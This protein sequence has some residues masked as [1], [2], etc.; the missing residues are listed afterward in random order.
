MSLKDKIGSVTINAY[1]KINLFLD[2]TD[3]LPNGYHTLNNV[4]QQIDLHDEVTVSFSPDNSIKISVLCSDPDIPCDNRNIAY[5][6]AE[7][8]MSETGITGKA[9]IKIVKNIPVMAGLGGS[10]TDG[11][12]VLSA[13]NRINKNVLPENELENMGAALGADL[14]FCIRGGAALCNGIGEKMQDICGLP[15][16]SILIVKPDFP[17]STASAYALYDKAPLQSAVEP[18][19]LLAALQSGNLIDAG[20]NL[21]N[22]FEQLYN[23]PKI[24]EIKETLL[25]LGAAGAALSGSGSALYGIFKEKEK[26]LDAVSKLNFSHKYITKPVFLLEK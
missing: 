12:A 26:A 23:D 3:T 2:I 9:E 1:A 6:A 22:I 13:L 7:R 24:R 25:K 5:K 18:G 16:C 8:F 11:A 21:Y 15:H 10:S 17:C 14:P 4:M 20:K 19:P